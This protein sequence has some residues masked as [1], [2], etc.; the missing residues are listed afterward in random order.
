MKKFL[1]SLFF[2]MI[3]F[4]SFARCNDD[5]TG[6]GRT[7]DKVLIDKETKARSNRNMAIGLPMVGGF[8]LFVFAMRKKIDK[9]W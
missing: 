3:L 1:G 5:G 8:Y 9:R 4:V 6:E 2:A 7:K